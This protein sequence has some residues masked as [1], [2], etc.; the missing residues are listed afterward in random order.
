ME[1]EVRRRPNTRRR[2]RRLYCFFV[3]FFLFCLGYELLVDCLHFAPPGSSSRTVRHFNQKPSFPRTGKNFPCLKP[4]DF[5]GETLLSN[6]V[7]F[8]VY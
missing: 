4:E 6:R 3:A 1:D 2:E 7:H 8:I 5:P